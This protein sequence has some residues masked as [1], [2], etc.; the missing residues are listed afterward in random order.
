MTASRSVIRRAPSVRCFPAL[1]VASLALLSA[2]S[3]GKANPTLTHAT[4]TGPTTTATP[5]VAACAPSAISATVS[6]TKFGGSSSALAGAVLFDNTSSAPCALHGVPAVQVVTTGGVPI[7]VYQATGP[8]STAS[9]V[10]DPTSAG[11]TGAE[12]ASSITFSSW[13]CETN[14]FSLTVRFPGWA[15]SVPA[16]PNA[17]SGTNSTTPCSPSNETGE[18]L[19]MGPV[20]SVG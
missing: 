2:C 12:A 15:S 18:T 11:A 16:A 20:E 6:F 19:Y 3:G 14:S 5:A 7:P 13:L 8:A 4:T 1:A 10:L 17:T 9:A